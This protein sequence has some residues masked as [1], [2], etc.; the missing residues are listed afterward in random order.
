MPARRPTQT[1]G[2]TPG[3][4]VPLPPNQSIGIGGLPDHSAFPNLFASGLVPTVVKQ[5]PTAKRSPTG[6]Q[7]YHHFLTCTMRPTEPYFVRILAR[8]TIGTLK[9]VE[10][11]RHYHDPSGSAILRNPNSQSTR[12]LA[13]LSSQR[14]ADPFDV[15]TARRTP[16]IKRLAIRTNQ[17]RHRFRGP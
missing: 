6:R 2:H 8:D 3:H 1:F 10:T 11:S 4:I 7:T 15:P 12:C 17:L 5:H 13:N 14:D 9:D 16:C